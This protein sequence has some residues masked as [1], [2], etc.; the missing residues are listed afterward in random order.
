[1]WPGKQQEYRI[2]MEWNG[3][4]LPWYFLKNGFIVIWNNVAV[5]NTYGLYTSF[6]GFAFNHENIHSV[7]S[8][9]CTL[10]EN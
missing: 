8:W 9:S 1:M 6:N 3:I 4:I 2:Q 10:S 5:N 7:A